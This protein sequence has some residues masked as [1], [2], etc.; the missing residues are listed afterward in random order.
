MSEVDKMFKILRYEKHIEDDNLIYVRK[1]GLLTPK[2]ILTFNLTE[3]T[4][5]VNDGLLYNRIID[6]ELL[7][8]IH[9]KCEELGWIQ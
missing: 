7:Q 4:I 2:H 3:R 1:G 6:L 9:K 5:K 8:A